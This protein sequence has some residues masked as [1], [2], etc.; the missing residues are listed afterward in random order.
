MREQ[1]TN[2]S[3]CIAPDVQLGKDVKLANFINLYGCKI[4]NETNA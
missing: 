2:Q 3:L 1:R 4:G